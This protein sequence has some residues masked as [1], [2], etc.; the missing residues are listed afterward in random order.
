MIEL[1]HSKDEKE[2]SVEKIQLV[3]C[4]GHSETH[5]YIDILF[6]LFGIA[7]SLYSPLPYILRDFHFHTPKKWCVRC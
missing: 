1:S 4:K 5:F 3:Y 6:Q 7:S 2:T